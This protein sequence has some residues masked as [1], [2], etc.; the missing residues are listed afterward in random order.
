[1]FHAVCCTVCQD[2]GFLSLLLQDRWGLQVQVDDGTDSVGCLVF[3]A[4]VVV[5][6]IQKLSETNP[7]ES[8]AI[9]TRS[10]VASRSLD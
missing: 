3:D 2:G 6:P 10:L 5:D 7:M 8:L 4:L 9:L 1:M